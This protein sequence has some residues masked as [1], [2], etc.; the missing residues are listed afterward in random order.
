MNVFKKIITLIVLMII[1]SFTYV[2]AKYLNDYNDSSLYAAEDFYFNSDLLTKEGTTYKYQRGVNRISIVLKNNE[3]DLR[4]SE[5]DI[6]YEIKIVDLSGDV[7]TSNTGEEIKSIIGTLNGGA[8]TRK[9][10][11]FDNLKTGTY[12]VE[13]TT[14]SPYVTTLKATFVITEADNDIDYEISDSAGS[15]V[16]FLTINSVDYSGKIDVTVPEG[17]VSDNT[18]E[19]LNNIDLSKSRK[20]KLD[21]KENSSYTYKFF[22][23]NPNILYSKSDFLIEGE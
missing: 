9:T 11:T 20:I 5:S 18:M 15:T 1:C 13:A 4:Y 3:D 22:K 6:N 8:I 17:L 19:A 21:F 10:V 14:K 2:Y 16:L 23:E 7:V 12:R